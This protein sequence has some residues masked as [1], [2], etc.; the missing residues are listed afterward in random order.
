MYPRNMEHSDCV[1]IMGSNMAECHPVAFRWPLK[2]RMNGATLIHVDPRFTR[3]S[4]NCDIHAPIRAGSDIAFLGGLINHVLNSERWNAEPFFK[5]FVSSYTNAATIVHPDFRDTEDLDGVYS[6]LKEYSENADWPYNGFVGTYDPDE[7]AIRTD[8]PR[9]QVSRSQP[10]RVAESNVRLRG[11]NQ[12]NQ[13]RRGGAGRAPINWDAIVRPLLK[14]KGRRDSTLEDPRCVC[15]SSSA[16]S[17]ATRPK[18]SSRSR[19]VR[20]RSSCVADVLANSGPDRTTSFAYAVAWTQHT[21]GVQMISCCAAAALL[22]NMGRPGGGIMASHAHPGSTDVPTLYHSIH[23]Y[24]SHPSAL[25]KHATLRDCYDHGDAADGVL[26]QST[27]V[28]G[29]VPQSMYGDAASW[30]TTGATS[31]TRRSSAIIR[32]SP[33]WRRWPMARQGCSAW[34]EPGD[35]ANGTAQRGRCGSSSGWW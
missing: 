14:P 11:R 28:H 24:M 15:S 19:G 16:T 27:E 26:G 13:R 25:K 10:P 29:L 17:P 23:G 30:T 9:R 2:A 1:V 31:G 18:W 3:T 4:A 21:D 34:A 5:S 35:I 22:G 8:R 6:G 33:P 12:R 32:T 20:A 7:L